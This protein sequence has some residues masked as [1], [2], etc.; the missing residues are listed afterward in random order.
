MVI[1]KVLVVIALLVWL[2]VSAVRAAMGLFREEGR[3]NWA[4]L[5]G[6]VVPLAFM[7]GVPALLL[8]SFGEVPPGHRG[9]VIRMGAVTDR[10]LGEGPYF[11]APAIERVVFM[12]VQ[13]QASAIKV[14]AASR[15][16]Q[17]VSTTI[18]LN[19]HPDPS[20]VNALY[21]SFRDQVEPRIIGPWGSEA[22]KATTAQF[23]AEKIITE[24][25]RCRDDIERRIA[26]RVGRLGIIVDGV[27]ITDFKFSQA[28]SDAIEA[29]VTA[30]QNALAAENNVRRARALADSAI[31][32]AR[33]QAE[34]IRLQAEA[35][36]V[37]GGAEYVQL[38]WIE[39]WN[40]AL[41]TTNLGTGAVPLVS[42]GK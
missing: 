38:K 3:F 29:K 25:V 42:V 20:R 14:T 17:D 21:Q 40:G 22:V 37:Q 24:R 31:A 11:V 36:R 19:W 12:D 33:G 4:A 30:T 16:L 13:V 41:P 10:V 32:T 23:E 35:V 8:P 28:F 5:L 27:A 1:L 15:D 39:K 6:L 26:E 18:T 7:I 9:I 2:V 34:T